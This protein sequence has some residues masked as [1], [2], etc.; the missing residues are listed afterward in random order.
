MSQ[1]EKSLDEIIIDSGFCPAIYPNIVYKKICE[2]LDQRV[3]D[4]D[5]VIPLTDEEL[6]VLGV[7]LESVPRDANSMLKAACQIIV[8]QE[9]NMYLLAKSSLGQNEVEGI[10]GI[11]SDKLLEM[12]NS[13]DIC[14]FAYGGRSYFPKFQFHESKLISGFS[15]TY[16]ICEGG[17]GGTIR[18]YTFPHADLV[19]DDM[20]VSPREWLIRGGDGE[21]PDKLFEVIES[22]PF[23]SFM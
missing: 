20:A 16:K 11:D 5:S 19:I 14:A 4:V 12:M 1:K 6:R 18:F 17:V 8:N 13:E 10:L 15:E 23:G 22:L 9:V 7:P 21:A 3:K 2:R